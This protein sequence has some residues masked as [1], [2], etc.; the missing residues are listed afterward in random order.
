MAQRLRGT[1]READV[2]SR[3]SGDEF[4][5][6]ARDVAGWE[7][8]ATLSERLLAALARPVQLGSSPIRVSASVGVAIYPEDATGFDEL[9]KH[10]D[11]AM[12]QAKSL[13]RARYSFFQPEFNTRRQASVLIEQQLADAL[14]HQEFELHYQPQV[15]AHSGRLVGCEALLRWHHP[16][17]GVLAPGEFMSCTAS[18]T[19]TQDD[20][21][22]GSLTNKATASGGGAT[23]DE[24]EETVTRS[25]DGAVVMASAL[26][27]QM[28]RHTSAG[29]A[30]SRVVSARPRPAT[31]RTT[32]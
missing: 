6:L 5:V 24:V 22:L 7:E 19:V 32:M 10:A 23:S 30:A 21:D 25:R 9:V 17:R 4:M 14:E 27:A 12:Y 16:E 1:L 2:A 18:D 13:G 31:A 8:L 15:H 20:F 26:V 11:V 28:S 29:L 3:H